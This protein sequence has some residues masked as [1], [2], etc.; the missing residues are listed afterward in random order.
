MIYRGQN[1]AAPASG[2]FKATPDKSY[3]YNSKKKIEE[4]QEAADEEYYEQ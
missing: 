1:S 2:S 3:N 4:S